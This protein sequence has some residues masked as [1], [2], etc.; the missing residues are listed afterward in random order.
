MRTFGPCGRE[1]F[2]QI[3]LLGVGYLEVLQRYK[4]NYQVVYGD[5]DFYKKLKLSSLFNYFQDVASSHAA[6]SGLSVEGLQ[7]EHGVTWVLVKILL[8]MDRFPNLNEEIS[9]ETWPLEPKKLEYERDFIVRDMKGNILAKAISSW[10]IVGTEKR[11][12]QKTELFPGKLKSFVQERALDQRLSRIK[13]CGELLPVYKKTIGYSD[14]DING[15][16]NNSKYIDY[17]TDCFSIDKHG[18]YTVDTIQVNYTSEAVAGETI[19]FY[20]DISGLDSGAVYVEGV[21]ESEGKTYFKAAITL[22]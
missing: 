6:N 5:S 4:K 8:K 22:K 17:I 1:V 12:I 14:I 11:E 9:V 16:L 21:D 15:H 19:A 2:I 20:K 3:K 10:V 18:K 7:Q 13:P